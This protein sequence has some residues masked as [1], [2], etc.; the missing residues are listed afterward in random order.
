MGLFKYVLTFATLTFAAPQVSGFEVLFHEGF[1]GFEFPP[2]EWVAHFFVHSSPGHNSNWCAEAKDPTYSYSAKIYS[3]DIALDSG[4]VHILRF[5][6]KYSG[7]V[8]LVTDAKFCLDDSSIIVFDIPEHNHDWT[9]IEI[10]V[11]IP[12]TATYGYFSVNG[13]PSDD[14][15]QFS[16][17]LD[18]F[19]AFTTAV[20]VEP[21]SLGRIK[22]TFE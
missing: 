20:P 19:Y 2:E 10:E 17:S 7:D 22:A 15:E 5:Y 8:T 16:W 4:K 3:P 13:G 9:K 14:P 11:R 21:V 1:E 18:D 12:G 6:S